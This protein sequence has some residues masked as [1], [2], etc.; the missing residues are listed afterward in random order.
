MKY[1]TI[2]LAFL[3]AIPFLSEAQDRELE[4][5]FNQ[6]KN[7]AGFELEKA[8]ADMDFDGDWDFGEFL[9]NIEGIYILGFEKDKGNKNDLNSF[10]EKFNRLIKKKE[11]KS[12]LDIE[13]DGKVQILVHKDKNDQTTDYILVTEDEEDAA[14]IWASSEN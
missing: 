5:L 6:Y 11:F 13:S 1:I 12:M 2:I 4:K 8:D 9:G 10:Q 3:F 7:K 14:F